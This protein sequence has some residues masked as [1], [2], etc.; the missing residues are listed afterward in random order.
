MQLNEHG[1]V[2]LNHWNTVAS[3]YPNIELDAFIVMPNHVHGIIVLKELP[4]AQKRFALP[5]IV[6]YF[7]T[8]T[9]RRINLLR[10]TEDVPV[11]QRDYYEHIVRDVDEL[12]AIR[13]YIENNPVNWQTD[14]DNIL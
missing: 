5:Q 11:W 9:A 14:L 6:R 7:K 10:R 3:N 13:N 4:A 1:L 2:V 12:N 8:Y